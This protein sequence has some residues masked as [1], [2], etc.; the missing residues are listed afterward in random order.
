M[1]MAEKTDASIKKMAELL[2]HGATMLAQACPQCGSP[3]FKV[4]NDTY[5]ATCNRRIVIVRSDE[6][7]QT[8][9]PSAVISQ[10]KETLLRKLKDVNE[11]V[12]GENDV[13]ALTKLARLMDLL[14][15]ALHRIENMSRATN[16]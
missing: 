13:E 12:E 9:A 6:D 7:M 10:L 15:Q 11:L 8:P 3:L 1:G 2:L 14:L 16:V 5:C 4:G